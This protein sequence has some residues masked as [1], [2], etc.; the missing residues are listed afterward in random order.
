MECGQ[1]S[2]H[3][4]TFASH[5]PNR[6][7]PQFMAKNKRKHLVLFSV[8]LTDVVFAHDDARFAGV[9]LQHRLPFAREHVPC[10][11]AQSER[12]RAQTRAT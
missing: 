9:S 3:S 5:F 4:S 8:K 2:Q 6:T 1:H 10:A 12:A 7:H 11:C